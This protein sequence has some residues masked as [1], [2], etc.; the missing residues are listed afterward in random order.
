MVKLLL[1]CLGLFVASTFCMKWIEKDMARDA[2]ALNVMKL[3]LTYSQPELAAVLATADPVQKDK[4]HAV[5]CFDFMFMAGCFP[6]IALLCLLARRHVKAKFLKGMLVAGALAQAFA[7][8]FDIY[9]NTSLLSWLQDP[10]NSERFRIYRLLVQLKWIL[11]LAGVLLVTV[12]Y[13][14]RFF[15]KKA[16]N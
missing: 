2:P 15:R 16:E 6:G 9:E 13:A 11:A 10:V 3:E 7:W 12:A 5:L 14:A 8:G 4:L 1:F